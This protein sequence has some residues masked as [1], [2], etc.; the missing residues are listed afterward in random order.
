MMIINMNATQ[1][2]NI[3]VISVAVNAPEKISQA[4][5]AFKNDIKTYHGLRKFLILVPPGL[6]CLRFIET[7]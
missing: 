5:W 2:F 7:P 4:L 1:Y 3:S 6:V